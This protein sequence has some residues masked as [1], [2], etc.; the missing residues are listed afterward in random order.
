[1]NTSKNTLKKITNLL[2]CLLTT[3]IILL[4]SS[5]LILPYFF[6]LEPEAIPLIVVSSA[7]NLYFAVIFL[8][9]GAFLS[10]KGF[11]LSR[12]LLFVFSLAELIIGLLQGKPK[13]VKLHRSKKHMTKE[14]NASG[15]LIIGIL[16]TCINIISM[17][18]VTGSETLIAALIP[19]DF[20]ATPFGL[21]MA[22]LCISW[23]LF[24]L[25]S[26]IWRSIDRKESKLSE[27]EKSTEQEKDTLLNVPE[28][29]VLLKCVNCS[30]VYN[31][32]RSDGICPECGK[33]NTP[34]T[35]FYLENSVQK[36]KTALSLYKIAIGLILI[37]PIIIIAL[38]LNS[39]V[40]WLGTLEETSVETI[41]EPPLST[42]NIDDYSSESFTSEEV[43][44]LLQSIQEE[45]NIDIVYHKEIYTNNEEDE[46]GEPVNK[47]TIIV[48]TA[49]SSQSL[50][51]FQYYKYVA[52]TEKH[53]EGD[54][55]PVE[56]ISPDISGK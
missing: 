18:P 17:M 10:D 13:A 22:A 26:Q 23:F 51:Y 11:F 20:T 42:F 31:Y 29:D 9:I 52:T 43:D 8:F 56:T 28:K 4:S 5:N 16:L 38:H 14:W 55:V 21:I 1:M 12:K 45:N 27:N 6:H 54:I 48:T 30:K 39:F 25:F 2:C 50:Y 35:A 32:S 40:K 19:S 33:Y 49:E 36:K 3:L 34:S 37:I 24:I 44:Q 47:I 7:L 15:I 41:I 53:N 46:E